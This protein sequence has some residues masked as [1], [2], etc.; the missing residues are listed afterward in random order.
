[1]KIGKEN[2][3][4]IEKIITI[5]VMVLIVFLSNSSYANDN[6]TIIE[7]QEEFK[8]QDFIKNAEKFT[9]EFFE[10]IDINEILNDAIKG[11]VDN[12]TLL[13][14]ILNILGKEVT[15]NIKSLV[16]ILAIILIHSILKSISES[17]ENNNI[18]KLIYYVQYI[19][20]VTVIMSNFTDI[21]KLV[22]DT[23]GNLI[24]FMN[25]LVPLLITLMMYTGSITT[26]SVVEPIILFMINFIGNIIQNLIIPFVLVLTS[27]VIISKISDKV[28]IDKLSKFFKSGIVWFLGIVLTVFVGIVSLEGTL[29]SSVDGIT[30]KTTKAVVSSAIPVVGKILGDAVDTVLGCGI[31]LKNAVGLVGVVIVIGI[32]IMPILKLF[33]LSVSYKLLSTVVQPIADEKIIDLLEQIGDIFKIF[34]GILCAISFMLII[35]TTLVL[36]ISN[37][38]MM[39]R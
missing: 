16:S 22:Q 27:L 17:L 6:Q 15:T 18:S 4:I 31:V 24:G 29:S 37:G 26:S 36:K 39:Y 13:K 9:G 5:I 19:L 32:C 21:I 23:T 2:F 20:I 34:L 33:V 30:A 1:M 11:E 38:T 35:G 10:D 25:A 7:Q 8:I 12:S 28:H 3:F 14:K